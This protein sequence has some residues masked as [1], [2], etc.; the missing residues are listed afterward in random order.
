MM[1]FIQS[2]DQPTS[3]EDSV[4][5]WSLSNLAM[6]FCGQPTDA[7]VLLGCSKHQHPLA[8]TVPP[9]REARDV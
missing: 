1:G 7:K 3:E 6:D 9:Q 8:A 4:S 5:W 2:L